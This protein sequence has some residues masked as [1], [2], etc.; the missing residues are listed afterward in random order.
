E[1]QAGYVLR[2]RSAETLDVRCS[3]GGV[4]LP[5]LSGPDADEAVFQLQTGNLVGL[6]KLQIEAGPTR[7][8][9]DLRLRVKKLRDPDRDFEW[10]VEDLSAAVRALALT[11]ASPTVLATQRT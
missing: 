10:L 9:V 2:V 8:N 3:V 11:V 5:R 1:E 6:T 7:L 4:P